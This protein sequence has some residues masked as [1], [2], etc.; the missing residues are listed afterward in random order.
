MDYLSLFLS[1]DYFL[2]PFILYF[3]GI[4]WHIF[5]DRSGFKQRNGLF[6]GETL[7]FWSHS[8]SKGDWIIRQSKLMYFKHKLI[9][10]F[11]L[12]NVFKYAF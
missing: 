7:K 2:Y 5:Y 12:I 3:Y 8:Y 1:A 6:G 11:P 4:L 9:L 10:I